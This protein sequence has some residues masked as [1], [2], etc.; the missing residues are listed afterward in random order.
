MMQH[1]NRNK[2]KKIITKDIMFITIVRAL[3]QILICEGK[4]YCINFGEVFSARGY[5]SIPE[6]TSE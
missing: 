1:W 5:L 3:N 6:S 2:K 4:K